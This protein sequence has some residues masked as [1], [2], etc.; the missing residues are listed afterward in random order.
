MEK[1]KILI[2]DDHEIIHN[3]IK[4]IL[5]SSIQYEIAGYAFNG[6]QAI[7]VALLIRPDIIFMDISMPE[8]NGIDATREIKKQLHIPHHGGGGL[9]FYQVK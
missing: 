4:D 3:G 5:K 2:V 6:R 7:E 1:T 9:Y 8:M